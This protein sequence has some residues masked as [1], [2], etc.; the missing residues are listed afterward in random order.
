MPEKTEN[1]TERQAEYVNA[2]RRLR[3]TREVAM[4][5]G[6]TQTTV[7]EQLNK[8]A[9]ANGMAGVR[10]WLP[11]GDEAVSYYVTNQDV[12]TV[13]NTK[14]KATAKQLMELIVSQ[15]YRCAL[16]G[17][18]LTPA[19][20]ALDH[21]LAV[22]AGGSDAIDNLQWVSQDVNR[23]KGAIEQDAFITMCRLVAKWLG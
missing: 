6:V 17:V 3:S 5:F 22:S 21:K 12:R 13:R 2:Y 10:D 14:N 16:S 15:E 18:L 1:L 19:T 23:A 11:S 7:Q 8:A 4:E 20:A 9:K